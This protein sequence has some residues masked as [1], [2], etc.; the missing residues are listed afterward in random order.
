MKALLLLFL[1]GLP[2]MLSG[3]WAGVTS[4]VQTPGHR[5]GSGEASPLASDVRGPSKEPG[6]GERDAAAKERL[7]CAEPA[8]ARAAP[9]GA[10]SLARTRRGQGEPRTSPHGLQ[11]GR[12][13]TEGVPWSSVGGGGAEGAGSLAPP[14]PGPPLSPLPSS[15]A[16]PLTCLPGSGAQCRP[17]T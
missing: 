8:G 11:G 5:R 13:V 10:P 3:Q 1:E 4:R 9:A 15:A 16:P 7:R 2:A 6:D 14:S 12:H 17:V